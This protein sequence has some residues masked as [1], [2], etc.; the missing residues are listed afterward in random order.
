MGKGNLQL[1]CIKPQRM[2]VNMHAINQTVQI[3]IVR[4][5]HVT[6]HFSGYPVIAGYSLDDA[7]PDPVFPGRRSLAV[8]AMQ[9]VSLH[10]AEDYLSTFVHQWSSEVM[11]EVMCEPCIA[12]FAEVQKVGAHLRRCPA[13]EVRRCTKAVVPFRRADG[14][15]RLLKHAS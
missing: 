9:T 13:P 15:K 1:T 14:F 8:V 5:M 12:R 4:I 2:L 6:K 7:P 3:T 11:C 10:T